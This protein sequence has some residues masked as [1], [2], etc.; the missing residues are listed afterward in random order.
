MET[1]L[2]LEDLS[3]QIRDFCLDRDWD[4]FHGPKD[5]AIGLVTES[6]ELLEEFRF[7]SRD[8]IERLMASD[9]GRER[10]G[11]ELADVTFF[12]LR[13]ADRFGFDLLHEL[14]K[15]MVLN[16]KKYPA[17]QFKGKNRKY[18]RSDL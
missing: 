7:L 3:K 8:Q 17:D 15:K 9:Q 5:L 11:Q 4:Q 16:A 6:S 13:F 14:S 18:N 2:S 1:K 10:V 12:L